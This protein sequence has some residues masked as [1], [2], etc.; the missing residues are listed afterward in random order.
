MGLRVTNDYKKNT[1]CNIA[2]VGE[3]VTKVFIFQIGFNGSLLV[4][5]CQ[6]LGDMSTKKSSFFLCPFIFTLFLRGNTK[7]NTLEDYELIMIEH[8]LCMMFLMLII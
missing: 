8:L 4:Y 1:H 2:G 5:W 6:N 7:T 3:V